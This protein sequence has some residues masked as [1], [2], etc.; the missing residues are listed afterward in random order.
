MDHRRLNGWIL[1]S[2]FQGNG[3]KRH[4]ESD[5]EK[6]WNNCLFCYALPHAYAAGNAERNGTIFICVRGRFGFEKL[7]FKESI[8]W[9]QCSKISMT[10]PTNDYVQT[11][12]SKMGDDYFK[13][14]VLVPFENHQLHCRS[15]A[16]PGREGR[17]RAK[18]CRSERDGVSSI[19]HISIV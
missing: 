6:N 8:Y 4:A 3:I 2:V 18:Q 10:K 12:V 19:R 11:N 17:A 14:P 7:L 1:T 16:R 15:P 13:V 9:K 5:G